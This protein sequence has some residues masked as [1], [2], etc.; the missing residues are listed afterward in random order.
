MSIP[1]SS[2]VHSRGEGWGV[3][4]CVASLPRLLLVCKEPEKCFL[5]WLVLQFTWPGP[6]SS[7]KGHPPSKVCKKAFFLFLGLQI[8]AREMPRVINKEKAK[9]KPP[10]CLFWDKS[11]LLN[12]SRK[13]LCTKTTSQDV[14]YFLLFFSP[15]FMNMMIYHSFSLSLKKPLD[16]HVICILIFIFELVFSWS[17]KGSEGWYLEGLRTEPL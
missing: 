2:W 7:T 5:Q 10:K 6:A 13:D 9:I 4:L 15:E 14:E 16:F 12:T 3:Q 17:L 11:T 8:W 1:P